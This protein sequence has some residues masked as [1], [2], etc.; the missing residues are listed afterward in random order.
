MK[1]EKTKKTRNEIPN[2]LGKEKG[3]IRKYSKN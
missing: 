3:T 2:Q 1:D